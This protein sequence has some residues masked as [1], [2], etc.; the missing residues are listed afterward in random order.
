[1]KKPF[2]LP[3]L[4]L[5]L[6]LSSAIAH[7]QIVG[8]IEADI[9]FAFHAGATKFPAGSYILR[10]KDDSNLSVMEIQSADG[11]YSALFEVRDAQARH[12]PRTGELIFNHVGDRYFLARIFDDS[13]KD[14][15]AV[16]DVGYSKQYGAGLEGGEQEHLPIHHSGS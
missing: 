15:G 3:A 9:P 1:M 14:G 8:Q 2:S 7:A 6:L 16:V 4:L 11:K 12:A 5:S 13:D 10:M